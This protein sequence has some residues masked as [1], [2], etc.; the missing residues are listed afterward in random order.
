MVTCLQRG[1][2]CLHMVQLMPLHPETPSSLA[3]LN[4]D[5]FYLSD[6]GLPGL[7]TNYFTRTLQIGLEPTRRTVAC[8]ALSRTILCLKLMTLNLP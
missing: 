2:D 6:T 8:V 4:P 3:H 7:L 5:W 1:A